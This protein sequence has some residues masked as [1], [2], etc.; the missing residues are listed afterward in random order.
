MNIAY[1][2]QGNVDGSA[3]LGKECV[4]RGRKAEILL[5]QLSCISWG[6]GNDRARRDGFCR[7]ILKCLLIVHGV[8]G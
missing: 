8:W 3:N 1:P 6:C 4:W 7:E 5:F 2:S